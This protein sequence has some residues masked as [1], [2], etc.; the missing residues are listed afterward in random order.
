MILK[1]W[2]FGFDDENYASLTISSIT[3]RINRFFRNTFSYRQPMWFVWH[4]CG[5]HLDASISFAILFLLH[6]DTYRSKKISN[7]F[8][9]FVNLSMKS[10]QRQI[11]I[12]STPAAKLRHKLIIT[13]AFEWVTI[14][15]LASRW[16]G[17]KNADNYLAKFLWHVKPIFFH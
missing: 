6:R 5:I 8:T 3:Q 11:S 17:K 12:H 7:T 9:F 16:K 4:R 14:D 2:I 10:S 15:L 1:D 13:T